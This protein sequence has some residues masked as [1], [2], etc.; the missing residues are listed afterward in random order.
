MNEFEVGHTC[1]WVQTNEGSIIYYNGSFV[2]F[3]AVCTFK[4]RM[5]TQCVTDYYFFPHVEP[6]GCHDLKFIDC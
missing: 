3:V 1:V 5:S 6:E 2:F 4:M